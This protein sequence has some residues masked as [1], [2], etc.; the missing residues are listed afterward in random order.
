V[1]LKAIERIR[2]KMKFIRLQIKNSNFKGFNLNDV[3]FTHCSSFS[4]IVLDDRVNT[5]QKLVV[6]F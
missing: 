1:Q 5:F 4:L 3:L 6:E 2:A